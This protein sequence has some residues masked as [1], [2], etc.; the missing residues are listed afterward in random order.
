MQTLL[1]LSVFLVTIFALSGCLDFIDEDDAENADACGQGDQAACDI[2][3]TEL[4]LATEACDAGDLRSCARSAAL[5]ALIESIPQGLVIAS[6]T[7]TVNAGNDSEF[8]DKQNSVE[9]FLN[10]TRGSSDFSTCLEA[11][12]TRPQVQSP[13]CYGPAL[14]YTD[15]PNSSGGTGDGQLPTGDLGLWIENEPGTNQACA[16]AKLNELVAK[17]A[18]NV[19]LAVGS[20]TMMVCTAALLGKELPTNS[21]TTLDLSTQ[22]GNLP[23]SSIKV[24]KATIKK[25]SL[26]SGDGYQTN[27][28]ATINNQAITL[29]VI[30]DATNNK[31]LMQI[32]TT[33]SSHNGGADARGTSVVY[34]L[35]DASIKYKMVSSRAQPSGNSEPEVSYAT[36]GQVTLQSGE[37]IHVMQAQIN[38][39]DGYGSLAYAWKAGGG[40]DHYRALNVVTESANNGSGRAYYGYVPSPASNSEVINLDLA[41]ASAGM[42]CNWAGPGN[43]HTTA[44]KVQY[45]AL[46]LSNGDWV[47]SSSNI[48]YVPTTSCDMAI[49]TGT[50]TP[51]FGGPNNELDYAD[52]STEQKAV[53]DNGTLDSST[54][55]VTN[56]LLS[57]ANI[58]FS[59]PS[60]PSVPE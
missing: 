17:A 9:N 37:D 55:A 53:V 27:L 8:L 32:E 6:S 13:W 59:L 14:N 30:H 5:D 56:D 4:A 10:D 39:D 3:D 7:S 58:N 28:K 29:S 33:E 11:L 15:H 22:L 41:H 12:P 2:L 1:K 34:E 38:A 51:T 42:I 23:G 44:D 18:Y 24:D 52:M 35:S 54:G 45:Q 57:K 26:T 48:T 47:A 20:M 50:F 60:A 46:S 40:D 31:G 49:N 36:D 16:A 21:T 25:A 43:S 19:D